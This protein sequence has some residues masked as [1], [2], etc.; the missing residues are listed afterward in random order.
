MF[1]FHGWAT[2]RASA[3]CDDPPDEP[4]AAAVRELIA[5]LGTRSNR[6]V[7]LTRANGAFQLALRGFHNHRD[8]RILRFYEDVARVAPGSYGILHVH[9]DEDPQT[10]DSWIC[11]VMRRGAVDCHRDDYLSP[12]IGVVEDDCSEGI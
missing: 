5:Q 11:W 10:H 12:H 6:F 3:G 4:A 2:I 1:E 7:D 9:D 8:Q